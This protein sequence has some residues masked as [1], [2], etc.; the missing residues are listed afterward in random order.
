VLVASILIFTAWPVLSVLSRCSRRAATS[1]RAALV[2]RVADS[3]I[4]GSA[5]SQAE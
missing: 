3:K 2:D 1:R 5:A 4:W